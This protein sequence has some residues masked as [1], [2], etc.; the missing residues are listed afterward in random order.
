M[1]SLSRTLKCLKMHIYII[2]GTNSK[3]KKKNRSKKIS[4]ILIEPC[5]EKKA[6]IICAVTVPLIRVFVFA[7]QIVQILLYL[8]QKI[9]DSSSCGCI[10]QFLSDLFG[11]P[12]ARFS[13]VTAQFCL[14]VTVEVKLTFLK[15]TDIDTIT[16]QFQAEIFVQAKWEEPLLKDSEYATGKILQAVGSL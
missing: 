11:N 16:Q 9:Q 1:C 4:L 14:Q 3:K 6:Q 7:T 13:H 15:I 5:H 10:G 2:K 8:Y 12:K